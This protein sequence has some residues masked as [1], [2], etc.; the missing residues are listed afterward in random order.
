MMYLVSLQS[1]DDQSKLSTPVLVS[2]DHIIR[3]I[4][5]HRD[6]GVIVIKSVDSYE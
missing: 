5:E 4:E 2:H 1:M 6:Q 3:Y